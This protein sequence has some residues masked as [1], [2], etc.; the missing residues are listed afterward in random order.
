MGKKKTY[1][2]DTNIL[3]E[4]PNALYGFDDNEVVITGTTLQELDS[5]KNKPGEL[6]FNAR[7]TCRQLE[8]L[9]E[10]G[11][12][13]EGVEI[14]HGGVV[15][16]ETE[17]V[18]REMLPYGYSID[19]PDN[20]IIATCCFLSK[21]KKKY[22]VILVTND[23]SMRINASIC[24]VEVQSYLN[25]QIKTDEA[26]L[27]RVELK[28]VDPSIINSLYKDRVVD[29]AFLGK[30]RFE[31]N[32]FVTLKSGNQSAL[33]IFKEGELHLLN[34]Q[35][36][37]NVH[38]K[39]A[40]Q[41]FALYALTAPVEE[42]PFVIL[43]GP[44]GCAKTFLSLAA[45][46]DGAYDSRYSRM[47]DKVLITRNNVTSDAEFGFLPGDLEEKMSPLLAPFYDNLESLLRGSNKDE[48]N[49]QIQMQ[50]EDRFDTGIIQVCPLAYVRGRSISHSYLIVDEA[51]NST[52]SQMRDI[53]TRAGKGTKIVICGDPAQIDNHLLDKYN[54]GLI[55]ASERMKGSKLC[56]QITF[57]DEESVR[58]SLATEALKRL[59]L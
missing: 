56:A 54:N 39:N 27:G 25:S 28:D 50:I 32:E 52:R 19:L 45:G 37:F 42:I 18:L 49:E 38:P 11:N 47:Y 24:G 41:S 33:T 23:V 20:R 34:D 48:S 10:K 16:V 9:R 21:E 31:E 40:A 30:I 15:R 7:E 3:L 13:R 51:Q 57:T 43:T 46:L 6:G 44:A 36:A 53:I 59:D 29:A 1:V 2:L 4:S 14:E 12:L 35:S 55:F 22:K 8:H 17:G 5:K 26:Y 58:S